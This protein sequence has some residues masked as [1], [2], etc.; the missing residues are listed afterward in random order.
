MKNLISLFSFLFVFA[1]IFAAE[2]ATKT[3]QQPAAKSPIDEIGKETMDDIPLVS[4]F[5]VKEAKASSP[6]VSVIPEIKPIPVTTSTVSADLLVLYDAAIKA[7]RKGKEDPRG[8][9]RAWSRVESFKK[10]NIFLDQATERKALWVRYSKRLFLQKRYE[11]ALR[12]DK[13]GNLFPEEVIALWKKIAMVEGDNPYLEEAKKRIEEWK[14]FMVKVN[15]YQKKKKAF[16]EQRINDRKTLIKILPLSIVSD[17]QKRDL[18]RKYLTVYSP[19]YGVGDLDTLLVELHNPALADA[20]KKMVDTP[21][22]REEMEKGC[23][24]RSPVSCLIAGHYAETARPAAA[25]A[26]YLTACRGGIGT[27]CEK[28]GAMSSGQEDTVTI[29]ANWQACAWGI[30]RG[31]LSLGDYAESGKGMERSLAFA[32]KLFEKACAGGMQEGCNRAKVAEFAAKEE[33]EKEEQEARR[34][35]DQGDDASYRDPVPSSKAGTLDIGAE[36]LDDMLLSFPTEYREEPL[37]AVAEAAPFTPQ[38]LVDVTT[39]PDLLVEFDA[40]VAADRNGAKDPRA[41]IAAWEKIVQFKG[42]NPYAKIAQERITEWKRILRM[43]GLG[44]VYR[45]AVA[46]ETV[47]RFFPEEAV[48]AWKAVAVAAEGTPLAVTAQTRS[49]QWST[50]L[51][52]VGDYRA[53]RKVV[54]EQKQRDLETLRLV[55]PLEVL[56]TAKKTELVKRY[57]MAY[58]SL[59]GLRDIKALFV[60]LENRKVPGI[61]SVRDVVIT[62]QWTKQVESECGLLRPLSCAIASVMVEQSTPAASLDYAL[63]ACKG[64]VAEVCLS[65]GDLARQQQNLSV[66]REA[67]GNACAWGFAR[68][69]DEMAA[70][71]RE[72]TEPERALAVRL[73]RKGCIDKSTDDCMVQKAADRHEV[74]P[75]A[76]VVAVSTGD[77]LPQVTEAPVK[78]PYLWYGVGLLALGAVSVGTGVGLMV[79]SDTYYTEYNKRINTETLLEMK[80]QLSDDGFLT[81]IKNAED[82]YKKPG[83]TCYAAGI[84]TVSIGA[85]ALVTGIVLTLITEKA[86]AVTLHLDE[87]GLSVGYAFKF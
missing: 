74:L 73:S 47:A 63:L 23:T 21:Q 59:M 10:G 13:Y 57:A 43:R 15:E 84:A 66:A 64:G 81:Y 6:Q 82:T 53:K 58:G 45:N 7:D 32:A 26:L 87:T 42:P 31:C 50:F 20:L 54:I 79:Q 24:E 8:A 71:L 14:S 44:D 4:P 52:R 51:K 46:A 85:V 11:H 65:T 38:V 68:G 12:M 16:A 28:V 33:R 49:E 55:L 5:A 19:Y 83:D 39:N 3:V 34:M 40:A 22:F 56:D 86:P 36:R 37:P 78:R 25:R 41:A 48:S 69:C 70:L 27:A 77:T 17:E 1:I 76:P 61:S 35:M 9:I 67:Y 2:P 18:L 62:P 29:E 30:A 72:G 80:E 75:P 60:E